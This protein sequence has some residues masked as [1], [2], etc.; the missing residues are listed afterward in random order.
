MPL[1]APPHLRPATDLLS[2]HLDAPGRGG[3]TEAR[4]GWGV[5][6]AAEGAAGAEELKGR[7][8]AKRKVL[9]APARATAAAERATGWR[10]HVYARVRACIGQECER[11]G[12]LCVR[13]CLF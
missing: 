10:R 9:H 4:S 13:L 1:P 11:E 2:S 7:V 3:A 6:R 12:A 8:E 5:G